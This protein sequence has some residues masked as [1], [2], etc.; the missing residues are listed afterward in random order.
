MTVSPT[1]YTVVAT[2]IRTTLL[3]SAELVALL[4]DQSVPETK[5]YLSAAN[6]AANLPYVRFHHVYGG[7]PAQSPTRSFDQLWLVC[8]VSFD[9]PVSMDIDAYLQSLLLGQRMTLID[10]WEAWADI[11]KNGEY[12]NVTNMQGQQMWEIG[13]YYRI[14]GVKGN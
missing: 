8:A 4:T 12:S 11:T 3:A 6:P 5:M 2:G 9:Q 1:V 13:A 14:R 10:G 7:E